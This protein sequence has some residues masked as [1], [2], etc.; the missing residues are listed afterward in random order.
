MNWKRELNFKTTFLLKIITQIAYFIV[1]VLLYS[2]LFMNINTIGSWSE[3]DCIILICANGIVNGLYNSILGIN[4]LKIS[5]YV[6]NGTLDNI[7]SKPISTPFFLSLRYISFSGLIS[8]LAPVYLLSSKISEGNYPSNFYTF[9]MFILLVSAAVLI[10]YIFFLTISFLSL[11]LV[12]TSAV[13]DFF[14]K[15]MNASKYPE[16]IFSGIWKN[17]FIFVL[18]VIVIANFPA[19]IFIQPENMFKNLIIMFFLISIFSTI[20]MLIWKYSLKQYTGVN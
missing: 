9:T 3:I 8:I 17:L 2:F 1:N 16:V 7:L 18:P 19:S 6:N 14:S 12:E 20:S 15:I 11:I 13:E 4:V 10:K 5:D